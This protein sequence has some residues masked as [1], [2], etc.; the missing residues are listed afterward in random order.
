MVLMLGRI[1]P[2]GIPGV[3]VMTELAM[4]LTEEIVPNSPSKDTAH[5]RNRMNVQSA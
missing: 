4:L 3:S 5:E 1:Q 2:L